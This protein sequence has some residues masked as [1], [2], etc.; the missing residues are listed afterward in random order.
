MMDNRKLNFI[1]LFAGAGGLSEGFIQAGFNPVAH[2][3]MN[4]A[5]AQTLE[6]RAA[7]FYLKK[8]GLLKWY[9][10][11]EKREITRKEL[12]E[13]VPSYV[14]K[15]IINAEMSTK[16]LP[17]IFETVDEIM[18]DREIA[19]VDVIIGGPPC[20]AYSL[21]GRAQSSHML[22]PMDKDPRNELYKLYTKFLDRYKPDMF[23][24]ENV[25]GITSARNGKVFKELQDNLKKVGY[26]VESHLQNAVDFGVLQNRRRMIIIGWKEEKEYYYP[27]FEKK[28]NNAFVLDLLQDLAVVKRGNENNNYS[29]SY[30][31]CSDYL[32]KSKIRTKNDVVTHHVAR[33]NNERDLKIYKMAIEAYQNNGEKISY[34]LLPEELKT[35]KNQTSFKDRFKVVEGNEHA[36][37]TVLAHLAKDG[38]YFIHPDIKQCRSITVREA[39]RI[40]TFPDNFY[41][42]GSRGEQFKQIGN[43]VPPMMAKTIAN[44]IKKQLF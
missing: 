18:S 37:H 19:N 29:L 28:R 34:D 8:R 38:H 36:C 31:K 6:T 35:H 13:H 39:A 12:F 41:F 15:T 42:E 17:H 21:V 40:Q 16:T 43:A 20:Q 9:R 25:A 3:E 11:Y 5:A 44:E 14:T 4:Y 23:V 24:F 22:V 7:Y 27:I 30:D 10:R 1:D 26:K 33:Y 2:V 32:K